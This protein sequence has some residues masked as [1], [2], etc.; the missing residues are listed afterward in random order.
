MNPTDPPNRAEAR[1]IFFRPN[2]VVRVHRGHLPHWRQEGV[3]YFV[4]GR[5]ADSMPR[6]KLRQWKDERET[7][8]RVHGLAAAAQLDRLPSKKQHEFHARFTR[9]WHDWLDAG[10]GDCVLRTPETRRLF[11][12]RLGEHDGVG[13]ELDA[14][15]AM[16]NHFHALVTPTSTRLG[17]IVRHWKGGSAFDI[18]QALRRTGTLWQAEPYDHIVRSAAQWR[19]FQRY[20]AENPIKAKLHEG[21]YA[22]G[23]G[24]IV[25]ASAQ[26]LLKHLKEEAERDSDDDRAKVRTTLHCDA[27]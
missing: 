3:M 26:S 20:A 10:Y 9:Q 13:Y 18:N 7:W 12:H 11:L 21:E 22:V 2:D 16:P 24:K 27:D 15:A 23:I 1:T 6:E 14:W 5:L 8:L 19:H 4:T 25:W 17:E